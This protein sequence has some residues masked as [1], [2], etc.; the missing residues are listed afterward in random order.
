MALIDIALF[1]GIT[2]AIYS[3]LAIGLNIQWGDTGLM[4]FAHA[5]FFGIGGYTAAILTT[6]VPESPIFERT[7]GFSLPISVGLI[8]AF[9]VA[10]VVG[11]LLA[12]TSLRLYE[13][14]LAMVTLAAGEI[15]HTVL[16]NESW[17]TS[18]VRGLNGIQPLVAVNDSRTYDVV[19]LLVAA[20]AMA[21][22]FVA[23]RH[24]SRSPFGR[25]LHAIREDE[26][27]PQALGKNTALF[28]LKSFALG[29]GLAGF[30]GGLWAHYL[31][32]FSPEVFPVTLTFLIWVAV[33]VGGTGN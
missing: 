25:V 3:L 32:H 19:F 10:A 23:F 8:A 1:L 20:A 2:V 22:A 12:L 31:G 6:P 27:V 21:V 28:K 30:A 9:V 14:Y 33:I 26:D 17:L 13:D 18:G 29:A 16:T 5:A 24:L 11:A 15:I 7:I 4:N